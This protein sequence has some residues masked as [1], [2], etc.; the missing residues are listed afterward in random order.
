MGR[1]WLDLASIVKES[2]PLADLQTIVVSVLST[3]NVPP[4]ASLLAKHSHIQKLS[5]G[6]LHAAAMEEQIL[7]M[8]CNGRFA[9]LTSLSLHWEGPGI[10]EETKPNI[11]SVPEASLAAIGMIYSLQ[12]LCL[13]AGDDFGW[14]CQWL[15]D[16]DALR[17]HL[18]GLKRLRKLALCRDS[19]CVFEDLDEVEGYYSRRWL[20]EEHD[21]RARERP[22]LDRELGVFETAARRVKANDSDEERDDDRGEVHFVDRAELE[23]GSDE[24]R[25]DEELAAGNDGA[26]SEHGVDDL[27][28][29]ES[30]PATPYDNLSS[31][32]WY[33]Y[34]MSDF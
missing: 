27:R 6:E 12:Q 23:G 17:R 5:V 3:Q 10:K 33:R 13:T 15:V 7:P 31:G 4:V 18:R 26:G 9:N 21:H 1:H 2:A 8:V 32:K 25:D 34:H 19:Y 14:C 29:T 20:S 28:M 16:H 30:P 22:D 24:E 11:A